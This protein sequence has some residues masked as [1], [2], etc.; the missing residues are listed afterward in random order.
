M[1][2]FEI[3]GVLIQGCGCFLDLFAVGSG[4]GAGVTG[5]KAHQQRKAR[6]DARAR[7]EDPPKNKA[8]VWF[9]LLLFFTFFFVGLLV[10]KYTK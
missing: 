2:I 10:V 9:V 3:V 5:V 7:G 1:E 6:Q 4:F 8:A